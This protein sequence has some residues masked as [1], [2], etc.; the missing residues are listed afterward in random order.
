MA[1]ALTSYLILNWAM[2]DGATETDNHRIDTICYPGYPTSCIPDA[3]AFNR[4]LATS[5]ISHL[6]STIYLLH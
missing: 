3:A 6:Y 5:H 4:P 2:A 1:D